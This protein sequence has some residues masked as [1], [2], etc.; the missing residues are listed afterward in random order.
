MLGAS[1][2]SIGSPALASSLSVGSAVLSVVGPGLHIAGYGTGHAAMRTTA[3][4]VHDHS[5]MRATGCLG[6]FPL[7]A[8]CAVRTIC[9]SLGNFGGCFLRL[10]GL[11]QCR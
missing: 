9:R 5:A 11:R 3:A 7:A 10:R 8:D 6:G 4:A 1:R 2:L